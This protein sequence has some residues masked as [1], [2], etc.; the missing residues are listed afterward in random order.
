VN[1]NLQTRALISKAPHGVV[2]GV[3]GS[4]RSPWFN[5]DRSKCGVPRNQHK[6]SVTKDE[7]RPALVALPH[8]GQGRSVVRVN[9]VRYR[10]PPEQNTVSGA[11][12]IVHHHAHQSPVAPGLHSA[13]KAACAAH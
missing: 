11:N 10:L 6:L 13:Q 1:Q 4:A 7:P 3:I 9:P 5:E 12:R 8:A 2:C